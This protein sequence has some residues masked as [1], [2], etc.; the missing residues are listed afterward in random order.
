MTGVY[1]A[2]LFLFAAL[3][4]LWARSWQAR[5]FN[6]GGMQAEFHALRLGRAA[7]LFGVVM[8]AAAW[9]LELPVAKSVAIV[10]IAVFAFQGMAVIHALVA[11]AGFSVAWLVLVYLLMLLKSETILLIG[12]LGI[13][14][15]WVDYR[16]RFGRPKDGPGNDV[17]QG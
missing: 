13:S 12:L 5:L 4:L 6:P 17:Q 9:L 15:A 8:I 2:V 10:M 7:S 14:D 16:N 11:R 1:A 3:A